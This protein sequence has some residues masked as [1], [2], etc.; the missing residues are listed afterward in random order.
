MSFILHFTFAEH[1]SD[2]GGFVLSF[3]SE[4]GAA[5]GAGAGLAEVAAEGDHPFFV[6][7]QGWS[8]CSP[9]SSLDR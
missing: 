6:S 3:S 9:A 1:C 8:S 2:S 7:G 4:T 5:A